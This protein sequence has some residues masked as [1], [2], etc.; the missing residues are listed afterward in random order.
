M[1]VSTTIMPLYFKENNAL[2]SY[3]FA[4]SAM[5][6]SGALSF[7]Y[8]KIVDKYGWRKIILIGTIIYCIALFG[9]IFTNI[10]LSVFFA[11]IGGL[12]AS[13]TLL[14]IRSWMVEKNN[15]ETLKK[16]AIIRNMV[17]Q[18]STFIGMLLVLILSFFKD[19]INNIYFY[20][21]VFS[22]FIIF[23][24]SLF[25]FF[26]KKNIDKNIDNKNNLKEVKNFKK[27]EWSIVV[28]CILISSVISG[29]YT[30]IIKPYIIIILVDQGLSDSYSLVIYMTMTFVQILSTSILLKNSNKFNHSSINSLIFFELMLCLLYVFMFL[31]IS[32]NWGLFLFVT[33]FLIRS[34]IL[35]ITTCFEEILH[36]EFLDKDIMASLI[37]FV[38][39]CFLIGDS[40]GSLI[41]TILIKN[42]Y[43]F[44]FIISGILVFFNVL[45]FFKLKKLSVSRKITV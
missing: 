18:F 35:S 5:A 26:Y 21:L 17:V 15:N 20:I 23:L 37:G 44:I 8:G 33:F 9:R 22:S 29:L 45:V 13:L 41:S 24:S 1:I 42:N 14:S 27:I 12:G 25:F 16:S 6:L 11:F 10:Y 36:Y 39:T 19:E 40:L 32:F 43:A 28:L 34:I 3:G 7:F 31:S 30:G 2:F 38:Q 4:Y